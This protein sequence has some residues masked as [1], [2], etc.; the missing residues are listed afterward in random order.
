MIIKTDHNHLIIVILILLAV[1]AMTG[2]AS[3]P[4]VTAAQEGQTNV[5]KDLLDKGADPNERGSCGKV[6]WSVTPLVCAVCY[7]H[8]EAVKVLVDR[9]ADVNAPGHHD[10]TPLMMAAYAHHAD[11]A[12]LLIGNGADLE[13]AMAE[14]KNLKRKD[15]YEFLERLAHKQQPSRYQASPPMLPTALPL[16]TEPAAPF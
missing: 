10:W 16:P 5:V 4:L 3:T 13:G 15:D 7:G 2:C 9:G 8:L 6:G 12:K 1:I 14:L 11:I